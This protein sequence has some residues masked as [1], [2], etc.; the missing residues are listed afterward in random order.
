MS[1]GSFNYISDFGTLADIL[2]G[3]DDAQGIAAALQERGHAAAAA[4]TEAILA[5]LDVF[6]AY[7]LARAERLRGV[8][9]AAEWTVSGDWS[10]QDLTGEAAALDSAPAFSATPRIDASTGR[11]TQ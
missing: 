3:K 8:W 9:K 6:E 4:E 2:D 7:I 5:E 11:I 1:G 10:E